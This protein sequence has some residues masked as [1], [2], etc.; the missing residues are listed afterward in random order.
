MEKRE[1]LYELSYTEM[2]DLQKNVNRGV[3]L[4]DTL[5]PG[6]YRNINLGKLNMSDCLNCVVGQAVLDVHNDL[7]VNTVEFCLYESSNGFDV[8]W[9][10]EASNGGDEYGQ[11]SYAELERLWT[12][13]V[14]AKWAKDTL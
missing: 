7:F 8:P 6:W 4:L 2:K 1:T 5:V 3:Q 13:A 11:A 10:D 14:K 9:K 12:L